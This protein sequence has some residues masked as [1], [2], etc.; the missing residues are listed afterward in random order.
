MTNLVLALCIAGC[1]TGTQHV[2]TPAIGTVADLP[3]KAPVGWKSEKQDGSTVLTP[4]DVPSGK[5]YVVMV[6]PITGKAG[7]LDEVY[8][9][10][11]KSVEEIGTF[12][13][14]HDP[15]QAASEGGWDYKF[16][17][18]TLEKGDRG[19]VAQVV[20]IKKGDE[21]G[22]IVVLS[23]SVETMEKYVD[24]LNAMLRGIGA[25]PAPVSKGSGTPDLQYNVPPGW[26][27][28]KVN[29][30]PL[31]VKEKN[32]EYTKYRVSLLVFPTE[33]LSGSIRE[34]FV[35]YWNSFIT[36]NYETNIA[37]IPMMVRLKSGHACAFGWISHHRRPVHDCP[38][39]TRRA[40]NGDLFGPWRSLGTRWKG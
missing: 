36:P 3:I 25:K 12:K 35:G 14:A 23:D 4:G 27:Q 17:L 1:L 8:A 21:G 40:G 13:P 30:F 29:G 19:L 22:N 11:K 7:S 5:I 39:R 32:E 24:P 9:T 33:P 16:V 38:R 10:G 18:G 37:P 34:Q 28:T 15:R 6:T 20:G 2:P 26:T 31:L